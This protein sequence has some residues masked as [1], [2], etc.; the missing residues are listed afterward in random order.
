MKVT[1]QSKIIDYKIKANQAQYDLERL[2]AKIS[3][4]SSGEI[5]KYEY[6]TGEDL[7]YKASVLE[8][9]KFDYSPLG[10]I[11]NKGLDE[12][13][14]K[15]DL[16]KRLRNIENAQ[17]NLIRDNDNESIYYTTRSQFDSKD[18]EDKDKKNQQN[19]DIGSK[20]PNVL[21]YLKSLSQE[22]NDLMH[23]IEDAEDDID[24]GNLL[25]I[26]S[27]W[28]KFNFNTFK[29]PFNFLS[30]IYNGEIL[31]KQAESFQKHLEKKIEQLQFDYKPK[32]VKEKEEIDGVLMQVN[33][34]LEYRNKIIKAFK[35]GIFRLNILKSHMMLL[36]IMC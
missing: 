26:G 24:V 22:A 11:F 21:N 20:P 15:E 29:M 34:M 16:F 2:T 31:L 25:F 1:D 9:T 17:K 27:N 28:K 30:D 13:D 35:D 10:K 7:S 23:E 32:N 4:L 6:L 5:R 12:D 3:A 8:Q 18:D 19:K 36:M 14:K 33:D